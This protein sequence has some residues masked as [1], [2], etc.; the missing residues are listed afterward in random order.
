MGRLKSSISCCR[1]LLHRELGSSKML[2]VF[3]MMAV[4]SFYTYSPLCTISD[5]YKVPVTPWIYPFYLTFPTMLVVNSG[6]YLLMFSSVGDNDGYADLMIAR[7]GRRAYM[8][9]QL[10][11]IVVLG[12]LYAA[13]LWAMSILFT[14]PSVR[15]DADWGVLLHTLT[16]SSGQVQVQTGVNLSI[17]VPGEVLST[18]TP[19]AATL[20]SFTCIWMA[21]TFTGI[22][23][24]FF[25][26]FISRTAGIFAAGIIICMALFSTMLGTLTFGRWLQFLSPLTW[27]SFI[28]LDWYYSGITPSPVY[29]IVVWTVGILGMGL[30]AVWRFERRDL[31]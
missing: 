15:W 29:A 26:V 28:Y 24:C 5:Y 18:F 31:G 17:S 13:V 4:F 27:A 11:C 22:L 14:I 19:A 12:I 10:L 25:K 2:L 20:M 9:G 16:E 1:T 21:G 8:I 6:M 23:I 30:A 7:S 3:I